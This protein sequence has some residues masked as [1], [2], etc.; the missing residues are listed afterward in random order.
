LLSGDIEGHDITTYREDEVLSEETAQE[1]RRYGSDT[2]R[3]QEEE[4]Y[5]V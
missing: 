3:V 1:V 2:E 5:R 4:N